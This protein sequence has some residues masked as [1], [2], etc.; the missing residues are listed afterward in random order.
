MT[1]LLLCPNVRKVSV[2]AIHPALKFKK[3]GNLDYGAFRPASSEPA[4]LRLIVLPFTDSP[5]V[6]SSLPDGTESDSVLVFSESDASLVSTERCF[7][8]LCRWYAVP[9]QTKTRDK[10]PLASTNIDTTDTLEVEAAVS[11][12]DALEVTVEDLRQSK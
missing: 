7:A 2:D 9:A 5:S 12:E 11:I 10:K 3:A 4:P 6:S 8:R 1:A